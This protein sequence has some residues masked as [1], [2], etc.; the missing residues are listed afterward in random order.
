M[1]TW[2][3]DSCAVVRCEGLGEASTIGSVFFAVTGDGVLTNMMEGPDVSLEATAV[4][5]TGFEVNFGCEWSSMAGSA[6]PR[7]EEEI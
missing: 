5:G 1:D 3:G 6:R 7:D 4:R 2:A